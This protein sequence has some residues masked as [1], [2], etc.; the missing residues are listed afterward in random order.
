MR[1]NID[2]PWELHGRVKDYGNENDI[3]LEQAYAELLR[4]GLGSESQPHPEPQAEHELDELHFLEAPTGHISTVCSFS[5]GLSFDFDHRPV[6]AFRRSPGRIEID[7]A[8]GVLGEIQNFCGRSRFTINQQ[9]AAW[10]GRGIGNFAELL[11]DSNI[12]LNEV[13]D[14]YE[15]ETYNPAS[16]ILIAKA[17]RQVTIVVTADPFTGERGLRDFGVTILTPG[18]PH[19]DQDLISLTNRIGWS[20]GFGF[21]WNPN[22]E[23][24]RERLD[25]ESIEGLSI[26]TIEPVTDE[27][28]WA[29]GFICENPFYNQH[30][31]LERYFDNKQVA[32]IAN[33]KHVYADL[34]NHHPADETHQ[35]EATHFTITS[36]EKIGASG[37]TTY[38]IRFGIDW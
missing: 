21:E 8:Q 19:Y 3:D 5:E 6:L 37:F 22:G 27:K 7:T 4:S 33:Y 24:N 10:F 16:A 31:R 25:R 38:D 34:R 11:A 18:V 14:D 20:F 2:I 32:Q 26:R 36:L 30:E 15:L 17:P 1:P 28:G 13:P 35:Y 29:I 9:N 12:Y 23:R